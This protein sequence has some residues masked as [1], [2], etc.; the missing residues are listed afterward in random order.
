M[1]RL[2]RRRV[3]EEARAKLGRTQPLQT[4]FSR[5][6]NFTFDPD[7]PSGL[8]FQRLRNAQRWRRGDVAGEVAWQDF[9]SALVLEFNDRFG[10][11]ARDLLAWQTL[12][13]VVGIMGVNKI[14]DC[15]ECEKASV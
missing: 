1:G 10:T 8:E 12:C 3:A 5:Y 13:A 15:E 4:Y 7:A 11:E 2:S 14:V 9:R 6:E